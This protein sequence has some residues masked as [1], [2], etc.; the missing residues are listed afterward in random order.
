MVWNYKK[1]LTIQ[2]FFNSSKKK[3]AREQNKAVYTAAPVAGGW[4]WAVTIW[5]GALPS[6]EHSYL[7]ISTSEQL[8]NAKKKELRVMD[9]Q[10]KKA[11]CDG[12]TGRH[13]D[14]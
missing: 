4:T 8:K 2:S 14:L 1:T 6:L 11:K 13:S 5:V 7:N 3:A 12:P 9:R 10:T